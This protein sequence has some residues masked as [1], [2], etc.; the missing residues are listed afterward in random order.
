[1]RNLVGWRAKLKI[2][3]QGDVEILRH[4]DIL[5]Q[6]ED[7]LYH[8]FSCFCVKPVELKLFGDKEIK[9]KLWREKEGNGKPTILSTGL[10]WKTFRQDDNIKVLLQQDDWNS[11]TLLITKR[12][13]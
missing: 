10:L 11:I 4:R 7:F 13:Y 5:P 3:K 9:I 12:Y 2:T 6:K 1:M 8:E